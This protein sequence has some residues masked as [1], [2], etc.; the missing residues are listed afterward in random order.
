MTI[1]HAYWIAIGV[2][3]LLVA[4]KFD[5]KTGFTSLIRFG[6]GW[7]SHRHSTLRELPIATVPGS[8]GYDGQFYAQVALD[9]L[10]RQAETTEAL[11]VPTYRARRILLPTIAHVLGAGRP[12]WII[13][14]FALLNFATW[15]WFAWTLRRQLPENDWRTFARWAACVFS[16]G[17]LESVRQSLVDLPALLLLTLAINAHERQLA[18][19]SAWWLAL[20]NLA[21]ESSL[22]GAIALVFDARRPP[23]LT[24]RGALI[25]AFGC[26]PLGIWAWYV[27]TRVSPSLQTTGI[28]NFT[29]PLAGLAGHL[30]NCLQELARGNW[31][32][33]FSMGL[34]GALGLILQAAV[35]WRSPDHRNSWWRVGAGYSVLLVF[36]GS[37]VW[38]GYWA[39]NRALLPMTIAF[40]LLL[41][42][43][44][45]A[46]WPLWTFGNL[47]A[48]HGLWRFL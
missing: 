16:M 24:K 1:R 20:A 26:L 27:S 23:F 22:L 29:W 34:L 18:R 45:P 36:I 5:P 21:K 32:G 13:Q 14:V 46:F 3:I 37:W 2:F 41:P 42:G 38:S 17:V 28:G 4:A 40:N 15:F 39:A 35:L 8:N 33:R 19:V 11:D 43:K 12:W 44:G 31:D 9:P 48:L 30:L 10:L 7:Q 47:T 6:E 25:L